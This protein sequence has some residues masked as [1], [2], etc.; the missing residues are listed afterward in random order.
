MDQ[1]SQTAT[2]PPEM[3]KEHYLNAAYTVRSWLLTLDHKRIALL[4]LISIT[5]FFA[6]G[7]AA[8]GIIRAELLT[9]KGDL[10]Q[11]DNYN[12]MFTLHG[13]I[14]I[15]FFLIPSTPAVLGNFLLPL[16]IGAKDLA[17]PKLN[18]ASWY[19]FMAGAILALIAVFTGGIDTG[20]TFYT[21]Y[22]SMYSNTQ[23]TLAICG[24]HQ[25]IGYLFN[26]ETDGRRR[27]ED[28]PMRLRRPGEPIV[29][30]DHH[31]EHFMERGFYELE[32]REP[33][34]LFAACG[35]PPVMME[36]HYC[37]IK[38][39]PDGFRILAST[40]ECRIQA[41]RHTSRPLVSVQFHPEDYTDRFPDGKRFLEAFFAEACRRSGAIE[42][43][44]HHHQQES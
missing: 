43:S 44:A 34:P 32:L 40:P 9:P 8:A 5:V 25:L 2:A 35:S 29:N 36:S 7:G 26:G 22:A 3:P 14:M 11:A 20:W 10:L 17:F 4:Y 41:M 37:E 28:K 13:V 12:K 24:A 19:V 23:V 30:A 27:L 21:P 39:L 18:L 15:F 38:R 33:D 1:T 16:M 6:V 42:P 31:P